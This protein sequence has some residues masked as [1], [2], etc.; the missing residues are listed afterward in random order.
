MY[1]ELLKK[2]TEERQRLWHEYSTDLASAD[3]SKLTAEERQ[4]FDNMDTTFADLD[5]R[6]AFVKE[7]SERSAAADDARGAV[8]GRTTAGNGAEP[9]IDQKLVSWMRDPESRQRTFDVQMPAMNGADEQ[10]TLSVGTGTAGGVTVP[11]TFAP[12]LY[13]FLIQNSAIRQTNV[14]VIQTENGDKLIYPMYSAYPS[15]ATIVGEGAAIGTNDPTFSAA[16]LS[17][18]KF[19]TLWQITNELLQDSAYNLIGEMAFA[20][21][22]ALANG[23]GKK[24]VLGA[25]ATEPQ[26]FLTAAGTV[27]Q[28]TGGTPAVNGPTYANLVDTMHKVIPQYRLNA[29][30]VFNDSTLGLLR[31]IVDGN[32]RPL[33]QP[34]LNGFGTDVPDTILGKPYVV[35]PYMPSAASNATSIAF[36]DFSGFLIREIPSVRLER[37]DDYA[38]NQ[39]LVT[40]RILHRVDSALI[41]TH[42]AIATYKGGTA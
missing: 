16:T 9:T 12:E 39:D 38:F 28:V 2:L 25:G 17:A 35:D 18:Y 41:D 13:R 29:S 21:G 5:K 34:G 6:I 27:Y 40:F 26:G 15:E 4:K 23:E 24:F 7:Q 42:G 11:S 31:K 20:F 10:R 36:G 30:W 22:R 33:W 14:K 37:S 3:T 1:D 32:Q 19:G 8:P